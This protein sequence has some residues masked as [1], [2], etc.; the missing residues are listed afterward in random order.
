MSKG[1]LA[2]SLI[3]LT[4]ALLILAGGMALMAQGLPGAAALLVMTFAL[5]ALV[6]VIVAL[7]QLDWSTVA[8]GIGIFILAAAGLAVGSL[9]LIPVVPV[10]LGL[11]AA[12]VLVGAGVFLAG[13]GVLLFAKALEILSK[14]GEK[15]GDAL[16]DI[17]DK[18]MDKIGDW[19]D[20]AND[21]FPKFVELLANMITLGLQVLEEAAPEFFD[22]AFKLL[23]S[24]LN[25]FAENTE[26]IAK[27]T[28]KLAKNLQDSFGKRAEKFA[29][30]GLQALIDIIGGLNAAIDAKGAELEAAGE[31][32]AYKIGQGLTSS[33]KDIAAAAVQGAID[34]ARGKDR[35]DD[36][37]VKGT[38]PPS[39]TSAADVSKASAEMLKAI[40]NLVGGSDQVKDA[41]ADI[42]EKIENGLDKVNNQIEKGKDK[43]EKL[44]KQGKGESKE[45]K[46]LEKELAKQR[47]LRDQ[48][49]QEQKKWNNKMKDERK[50]LLRLSKEYDNLM[51][52][53]EKA[54]DALEKAQSERDNFVASTQASFDQ[55]PDIS[56][57]M[58]LQ[59]YMRQI[60]KKTEQTKKFMETLQAL[61]AAGLS[62][63]SYEQLLAEGVD[64]QKLMEQML[65][66]GGQAIQAF[67]AANAAMTQTASSL[68][69]N[70]STAL[71]YDAAVASAQATLDGWESQLPALEHEMTKVA[72][73]MIKAIK[74]A[75]GIKSPS[76]EFREVADFTTEGFVDG[77]VGGISA[78]ERASERVGR[79]SL[80]TLRATMNKASG[81][82]VL[83]MTPTIAPVLDLAQ[84]QRDA[85]KIG[86]MLATEPLVASVSY[87]K[88]AG[89][90][91]DQQAAL[92]ALDLQ[93]QGGGDTNID[94]TQIL[95]SPKA[96]SPIDTYRATKSAIPLIKEALDV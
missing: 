39:R 46:A 7:S 66:G 30:I 87:E 38:P 36:A 12:I 10:L 21:A 74:K 20:K 24:F 9:L 3:A 37:G 57:G 13:E 50:E 18:F 52:E 76:R 35:P 64:A 28:L 8:K 82:G 69:S 62:D 43:L 49:Q 55:K 80:E 63:A 94:Y 95:Q 60:Q 91:A 29:K 73:I 70:A 90:S 83:D 86:T 25:A 71:Y 65:Q 79:A 6:P 33:L 44:R 22:T 85:V 67:N 5:A 54:T 23:I 75:L 89:I 84:L 27:A 68:A 48:L 77:L 81:M 51:A 58:S 41:F 78:V 11:A 72:R 93:L 2:K 26:E 61:R 15:G 92:E 31:D 16:I 32:M 45:A 88:A 47:K 42:E 40:S 4:A 1:D 53:I 96:I 34:G 59:T 14:T 19:L 17:F 56:A